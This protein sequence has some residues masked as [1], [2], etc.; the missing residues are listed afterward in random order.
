MPVVK[1]RREEMNLVKE[2]AERKAQR[3]NSNFVIKQ[4]R[5]EISREKPGS[6]AALS[7]SNKAQSK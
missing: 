2:A 7:A 4:E 1:I 5:V 3:T 6:Q